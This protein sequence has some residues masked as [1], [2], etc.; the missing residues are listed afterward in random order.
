MRRFTP[1]IIPTINLVRDRTTVLIMLY[2]LHSEILEVSEVGY[3][4]LQVVTRSAGGI[5]QV[6]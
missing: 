5:V 2:S 6:V 1:K 3:F 4:V